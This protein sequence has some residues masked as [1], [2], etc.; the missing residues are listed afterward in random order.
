MDKDIK[1]ISG[2]GPSGE[3]PQQEN[4]LPTIEGYKLPEKSQKEAK[5]PQQLERLAR[6]A[7]P[8]S[9]FKEAQELNGNGSLGVFAAYSAKLREALKN[10]PRLKEKLGAT[11]ILVLGVVS[12]KWT[13]RLQQQSRE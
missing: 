8:H 7:L 13:N 6:Q 5:D 11:N 12:S 2:V 1:N 4:K 10:N 3:L 9:A